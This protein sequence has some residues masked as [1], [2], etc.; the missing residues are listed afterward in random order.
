MFSSN[1]HAYDD[2]NSDHANGIDNNGHAS[3]KDSN[4]C[5]NNTLG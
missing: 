2:G 3:D 5:D 1:V 4:A